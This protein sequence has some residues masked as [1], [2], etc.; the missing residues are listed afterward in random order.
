[1]RTVFFIFGSYH[2]HREYKILFAID[3]LALFEGD[4]INISQL[5]R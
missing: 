2:S 3:F 5:Q 4:F 1:M